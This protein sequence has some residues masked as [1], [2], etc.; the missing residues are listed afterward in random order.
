[1]ADRKPDRKPHWRTVIK[2]MDP[3]YLY[4][5]DLGGPGTTLD[6]EIV[7]SGK[8]RIKNPG[9]AK[10]T[11]YIAFR[12]KS[13]K[14]G[15]NATMAKELTKI[16]G[17]DHWGDWRGWI[18]L[19]VVHGRMRDPTT[20]KL[21]DMDVIRIAPERPRRATNGSRPTETGG[22]PDAEELAEIARREAQEGTR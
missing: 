12:G 13:K 1:M 10:D 18:T 22:G 2:R 11:L 4:A 20:E 7:D 16:C 19:V 14:L 21:E 8:C 6:V 15:L 3:E 9:G 5:E 17:S